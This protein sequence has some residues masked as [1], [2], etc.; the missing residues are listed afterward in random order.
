MAHKFDPANLTRLE[1]PERLELL[2]IDKVIA[3]LEVRT[4]ERVLDAGCGTGIFAV[5]LARTVG[6]SGRVFAVDL[7]VEMVEACRQR[8]AREGVSNVEVIQ[9]EE[10]SIP[11]PSA[12]VDLAFACHLLHELEDPAKFLAEVRRV[13]VPTGRLAA[14]EWEKVETGVGPP[15]EHR[16]TPGDSRAILEKSNFTVTDAR[17]VTW[18]NYLLLARPA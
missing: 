9:S 2:P 8:V 12:S 6:E 1:S 7:S 18:A 10:N 17:R 13:L 11:V 4:G 16:L 14:I 5:P 3:L 15:L